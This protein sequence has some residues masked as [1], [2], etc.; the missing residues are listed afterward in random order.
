MITRYYRTF[1]CS[2]DWGF[3][4]WSFVTTFIGHQRAMLAQ[5]WLLHKKEAMHWDHAESSPFCPKRTHCGSLLHS[6][7]AHS[8]SCYFPSLPN[9]FAS[10]GTLKSHCWER[11]EIAGEEIKK[12]SKFQYPYISEHVISL[13]NLCCF[14][15]CMYLAEKV[16]TSWN[17]SLSLWEIRKKTV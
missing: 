14:Q 15:C 11:E 3:L 6:T 2:T 1:H 9:W 5:A 16:F 12:N 13:K 17:G 4:L 10:S 8:P 7:H